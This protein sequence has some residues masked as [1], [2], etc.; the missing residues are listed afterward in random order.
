MPPKTEAERRR[1]RMEEASFAERR[2]ERGAVEPAGRGLLAD[3]VTARRCPVVGR[4]EEMRSSASWIVVSRAVGNERVR[5]RPR[6][7]NEVRRM[8]MSCRAVELAMFAVFL[9]RRE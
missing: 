1:G 8:L 3:V 2:D 5:G 9:L 4:R 6:P 7:A